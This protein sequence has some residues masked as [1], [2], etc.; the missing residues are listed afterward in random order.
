MRHSTT[1][2]TP[3]DCSTEFP[4]LTDVANFS[5]IRTSRLYDKSR[6]CTKPGFAETC[7]QVGLVSRGHKMEEAGSGGE[8]GEDYGRGWQQ[9]F[10][11]AYTLQAQ[12]V[13]KTCLKV[14]P[15]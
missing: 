14:V 2:L 9:D 15:V 11:P 4:D 6:H 10:Q 5:D 7:I 12:C 8:E 3:A 13:T 1:S